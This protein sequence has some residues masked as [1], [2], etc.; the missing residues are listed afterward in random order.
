[1]TFTNEQLALAIYNLK[2]RVDAL[3]AEAD[4]E[5]EEI[6][7]FFKL[8]PSPEMDDYI[9][10]SKYQVKPA[11]EVEILTAKP[12]REFELVNQ[13]ERVI[14]EHM[15]KWKMIGFSSKKDDFKIS[16]SAEII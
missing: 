1:M 7:Q 4:Q 14:V 11:P 9:D 5:I 8:A 10:L 3:E 15:K 6:E 12:D 16:V 2:D 13:A